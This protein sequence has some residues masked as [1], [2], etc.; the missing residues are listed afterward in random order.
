[1]RRALYAVVDVYSSMWGPCEMVAAHFQNMFFDLGETLGMK[2]VR[3]TSDK[4]EALGDYRGSSSSTFLFMLV[5]QRQ[6]PHTDPR[7]C[8]DARRACIRRHNAPIF[9][10]AERRA[11]A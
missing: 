3:A 1:M 7:T 10:L 9:Y 5:R 6:R 2:F 4:I 8:R 11:C